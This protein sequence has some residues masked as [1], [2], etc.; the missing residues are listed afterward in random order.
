MNDFF[1]VAIP[2]AFVLS[3]FVMIFGFIIF[4]RLIGQKERAVLAEFG[5]IGQK[6]FTQVDSRRAVLSTQTIEAQAAPTPPAKTA[7][8]ALTNPTIQ[9]QLERALTYKAQVETL[10]SRSGDD[11]ANKRL[12]D[13]T[14]QVEAW[15]EAIKRLAQ[16]VD[17]FQQDPLIRRDLETVPQSIERLEKQLAGETDEATRAELERTLGNHQKQWTSLRQLQN[18]V[19]RAEIQIESTLS[20]LGT[21]Y[22]QLLTNQSTSHIADYNHFSAEVD[23]EVRRL[24]DQLEA[25]QEVKFGM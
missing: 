14:A 16:R 2:C 24:Q 7:K 10:V 17:Y 15:V 5:L 6:Q 20:A 8:P 23:E 11:R 19:Q 13:L 18:I 22:S 4:M 9:A 21:I 12:K 1:E 25:L 3:F